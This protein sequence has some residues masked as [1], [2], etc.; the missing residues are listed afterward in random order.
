MNKTGIRHT[1]AEVISALRIVKELGIPEATTRTGISGTLL[2]TW[3]NK[4]GVEYVK[5]KPAKRD[6]LYIKSFI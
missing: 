6:W 5:A 4:A 2:R 1:D 3:A